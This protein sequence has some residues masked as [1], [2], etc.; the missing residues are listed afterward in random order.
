MRGYE[1]L[2]ENS[3]WGRGPLCLEALGLLGLD[4]VVGAEECP[5]L[6]ALCFQA[7]VLRNMPAWGD[8]TKV[9]AAL[10]LGLLSL[11]HPGWELV[12][13]EMFVDVCGCLCLC[14]TGAMV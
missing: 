11:W 2:W 8:I 6:L 3:V 14:G 12:S 5:L 10:Y 7:C 4:Q 9:H 1:A 13:A